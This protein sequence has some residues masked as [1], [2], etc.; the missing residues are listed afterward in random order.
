MKKIYFLIPIIIVLLVLLYLL[1]GA[2]GKNAEGEFTT[3]EVTKG[4]ISIIV[5]ATGTL[6]AVTTVLVGS[7]VSGI[8]SALYADFND[9]VRKG[10]ILAQL[11]PTFLKA[12]V[13]QSQADLEKTKAT[14]ALN[15]KEYER[16]LSLYEK[17][18]ISESDRDLA[19]TNYE[20]TMAD[21]KSSE[22]SLDR[23]KTN[24]NYAT[25]YSPI[26]GVVISRDVDVGQTVAASLSAPTLFTIANDLREMEV[27]AS[28]D[29][30]DIGN[31][32]DGQ[33]ASFTVDA[34]PDSTFQGTVK[35]VRLSPVIVQ[36][37]VTYDV[38]ISVSNPNML[39]KP[40][41]TANVT[42]I[43][44]HRENV[45]KVPSS[46]LRFK[47]TMISTKPANTTGRSSRQNN[48]G[49]A[50]SDSSG[51][52]QLDMNSGDRNSKTIWILTANGKVQPVPVQTGIS[53]GS[54]TQI[55]SDNIKEGDK[56]II[57]QKNLQSS[58]NNQQQ[59]NPFMPGR[60]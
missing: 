27:D 7:Q 1:L 51:H 59:V 50:S 37:V 8:I 24:Q 29:E 48:P 33:V 52:R 36:N 15:K 2:K 35:Q 12:Q 18:M 13:A 6:D 47:P 32:K 14:V 9:Q 39:L 45:L 28:I 17:K 26:D 38:I 5:T 22:A 19:Y 56:V 31:I 57:G 10:Q 16:S 23:A 41:M 30:A 21:E 49:S 58:S 20:L 55:I 25:I 53:D 11:D 44:D 3:T 4:N 46:A 43:V 60:H 54:S 42:I 34:Y 40:G